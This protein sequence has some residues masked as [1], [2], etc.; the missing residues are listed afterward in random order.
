VP[1][2]EAGPAAGAEKPPLPPA[3][4][5]LLAAV[6]VVLACA[7]AAFL[8]T[9]PFAENGVHRVTVVPTPTVSPQTTTLQPSP[10][11]SGPVPYPAATIPP[12][13]S[14]GVWVRIG[15]KYGYVADI[16]NP[17][18]LQ[19]VGGTGEHYYWIRNAD[20]LVQVSIR[21]QDYSADPLFVAVYRNGSEIYNN[22][23]TAP[24]GSL[25]FIIDPV[26]GGF[27]GG[28][29]T[30]VSATGLEPGVAYRRY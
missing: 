6:A 16:G 13:F 29:P 22:T 2:G 24:K 14:S 25:D 18:S 11:P 12:A 5:I 15:Y 10:V 21:K 1:A 30:P 28:I 17:G 3:G 9:H 23:L 27:P 4:T 8:F 20:G 19:N 7:A 26:T